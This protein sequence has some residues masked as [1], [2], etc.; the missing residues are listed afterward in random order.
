MLLGGGLAILV[1]HLR[2]VAVQNYAL[3]HVSLARHAVIHCI[4]MLLGEGLARRLLHVLLHE[5]LLIEFL[6]A[7][8]ACPASLVDG[9]AA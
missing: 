9:L 8:G 1:G 7:A 2:R 4:C 6:L 5:L 3:V